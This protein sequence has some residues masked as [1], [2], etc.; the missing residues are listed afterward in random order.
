M[1][2]D[3]RVSQPPRPPPNTDSYKQRTL[4]RVSNAGLL[5][6]NASGL[7]TAQMGGS[8]DVAANNN[9]CESDADSGCSSGARWDLAMADEWNE[10]V[11]QS[12]SFAQDNVP[13]T[14]LASRLGL[15]DSD[16]V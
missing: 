14:D 4:A 16:D 15:A 12:S 5:A 1:T 2:S 7:T 6:V 9:R 3:Q 13:A 10:M 11:L 8:L